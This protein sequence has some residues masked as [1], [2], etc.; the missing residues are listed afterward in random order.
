MHGGGF[1]LGGLTDEEGHCRLFAKTFGASCI[2]IDYRL[3]PEYKQPTAA[4]DCWDVLTWA[5]SH[6]KELGADL[7]KGFLVQGVSAGAVLSDLISRMA[8]D[9]RLEPPITGQLQVATAVCDSI[10]IPDRYK[11]QYL[12]WDQ[13]MSGSLAK[14]AIAILRQMRAAKPED[15]WSSPMVAWPGG[16]E[17]L[18]RTVLMVHGRDHFRDIGL[19]YER[20]LR[21]EAGVDTKLYVYP[22]LQHGF[23]V[24][25]AGGD[26]S[27]GHLQDMLEGIRWLLQ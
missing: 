17:G 22:G 4:H 25:L 24:A 19:I 27:K 5:T 9:A 11:N 26:A 3:A 18:P 14:E 12:S 10:M 16:N 6:T 20:M 7:S 1:C 2:N 21:E 13:D 8:R 23:N 15:Q